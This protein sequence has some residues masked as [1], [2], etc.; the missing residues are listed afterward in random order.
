[1]SVWPYTRDRCS[2]V[3]TISRRVQ[4]GRRHTCG[5]GKGRK[6]TGRSRDTRVYAL[7]LDSFCHEFREYRRR[8]Y[9]STVLAVRRDTPDPM[10]SPQARRQEAILLRYD[11]LTRE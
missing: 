9:P 5:F 6:N 2:P 8:R 10:A 11:G 7:A 1:M 4:K 3:R